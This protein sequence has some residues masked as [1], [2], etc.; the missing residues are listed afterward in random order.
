MVL[1]A[2]LFS[3]ISFNFIIFEIIGQQFGQQK[4]IVKMVP[5]L[6]IL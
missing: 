6:L 5:E 2:F 4:S 3:G 1:Q